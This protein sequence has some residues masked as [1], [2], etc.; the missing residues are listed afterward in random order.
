MMGTYLA[1]V[2][3]HVRADYRF[4]HQTFY[5]VPHASAFLGKWTLMRDQNS[6]YGSTISVLYRTHGSAIGKADVTRKVTLFQPA[7]GRIFG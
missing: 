4:C 1:Y 3:H 5:L 6:H 2:R 7:E